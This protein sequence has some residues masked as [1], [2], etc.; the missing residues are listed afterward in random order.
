MRIVRRALGLLLPLALL[1]PAPAQGASRIGQFVLRCTYS[2][3][4]ADD[5]IV[6]PDQPGAS[7]LHDFFGNKTVDAFSTV[8][9]L[10][11]GDTTC[12]VPSDTAGYWAPTPYLS[13]KQ[14]RP[15]VMRIYY[16][17]DLRS[18]ET[19]PPG[20][21]MIGGNKLATSPAENPHV[22]W[23]CGQIRSQR[24]PVM[25]HP[26][27]CRPW[28]AF[29]FVDGVIAII[30]MPSCWDGIGLLPEDVAYPVA[31]RECPAGFPHVLPRLSE[32]LHLGIM[33]PLNPDGSLAL[34]LSSGPFYTLHADFWNTWQQE[35]LDQLV[36]ECLAAGAHCGSVD[37]TR[38][39]DWTSQFGTQRYDLAYATAAADDG[40]YVAGFTNYALPGQRYHHR[41]DAFVRKY[42]ASGTEL[43]TRQF[44]TPGTDQGLAL[45]VDDSGVY[46]TGSTD[47]RF[48][49]QAPAGELDA[50]VAKFGPNGRQVWLQQFGTRGSDEAVSVVAAGAGLFISG[51]TD[52]RLGASRVGG[53]D[54]FVGAFS[55]EGEVRWIRQ[56]GSTGTDRARGLSVESGSVRVVGSTDGAF[57]GK[58]SLGGDDA[59][60]QTFTTQGN[61]GWARQ[62]G[63]SGA[64]AATSVLALPGTTYVTGTTDG[65]L[66]GQASVGGSDAFVMRLNAR[67]ELVWTRQF[68]TEASDDS[69]AVG[70]TA[71]AVYV[72][73][74]TT[75]ALP[76]QELLGE[77][78][79]FIRRYEPK[80]TEVWTLQ[81]G[82]SDYD[83][84]YGLALGPGAAY[85]AGT[86]HGA[87]EGHVN[88]G[89]RDVFLTRIS[90]A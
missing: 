53:T 23:S 43:W 75:G 55:L 16:F 89:D 27:D 52:G 80:G 28:Q 26:Y 40:V 5:P 85:V 4:L 61:R 46:V 33:N 34:T 39:I 83:Q 68:G 57:R 6:F 67:G 10:L 32:R 77:T 88:A 69:A 1:I 12:R 56:F 79:A 19:I 73:G 50:F 30:E 37:E 3:T 42:D 48:P 71:D 70:G 86:T 72:A 31:P 24:T 18:V 8:T 13:G 21:Q 49:K 60:V 62:L 11:K 78:D 35:R 36:E 9:S 84:A 63:S 14:L 2:H 15:P 82:T 29:G 74:S 76:E 65:T 51:S 81:L 7:H 17:G 87:F 38:S 47:G 22:G 41:Y 25:D 45:A 59:F 58:A 44:G 54:A 64:D 66:Q 90:L 20:L